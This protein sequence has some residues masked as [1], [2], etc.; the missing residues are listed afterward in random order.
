M[1]TPHSRRR[2]RC[3]LERGNLVQLALDQGIDNDTKADNSENQIENGG[4]GVVLAGVSLL[5]ICNLLAGLIH[6]INAVDAASDNGKNNT[7][8]NVPVLD[9]HT[10]VAA[11][12]TVG[13]VGVLLVAIGLVT[14]LLIG[15]LLIAVG[16]T[17][18]L[19]IVI[20]IVLLLIRLLAVLLVWLLI[21]LLGSEGRTQNLLLSGQLFRNLDKPLF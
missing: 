5:D 4:T 7:Q 21:G 17:V 19:I 14:I 1:S 6:P 2:K 18:V 8:S 11:L 9:R 16:L 13:L 15:R 3:L 12:R 20:V 10:V